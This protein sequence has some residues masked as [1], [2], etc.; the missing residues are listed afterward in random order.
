MVSKT[1]HSSCLHVTDLREG[2]RYNNFIIKC[3]K[4]PKG[5]TRGVRE[6]CR[7]FAEE[8]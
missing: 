3:N 4:C 7:G 5:E 8:V 6:F 2:G 1:R